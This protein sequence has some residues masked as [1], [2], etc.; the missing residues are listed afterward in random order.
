MLS[1]SLNKHFIHKFLNFTPKSYKLAVRLSEPRDLFNCKRVHHPVFPALFLHHKHFLITFG[2]ITLKNVEQSC[3]E[4]DFLQKTVIE[5]EQFIQNNFGIGAFFTYNQQ[6]FEDIPPL[7]DLGCKNRKC[8]VLL[9]VS[10]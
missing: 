7:T 6:C 10:M 5:G 4:C 8:F 2:L 3:S 9:L 1:H